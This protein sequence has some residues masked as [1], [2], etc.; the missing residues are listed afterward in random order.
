MRCRFSES[1]AGRELEGTRLKF[2]LS[3]SRLIDSANEYLSVIA[4]ALV[5]LSCLISAGNA[6]SRYAFSISSNA[7][8]EIQWYMFGALVMLGAS[9]TLRKNE[10]VRVDI[11]YT[12]LPTRAQIWVDIGG[13]LLFL[14]P[15]MV[16][17]SYLSWPVF[18]NSW[19]ENEISGNAGGLTRWYVKIFLPLGFALV[20]LQGLSELIKRVAMLTGHMKAD[21]HYE[22]PL[23]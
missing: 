19:V 12:N 20:S 6:F 1:L 11:V 5:L 4:D 3:L 22:R 14:L 8:L 21:T 23:Q 7:W 17:M 10:H 2:L 16:I 9:Y 15:A 13:T 18:H